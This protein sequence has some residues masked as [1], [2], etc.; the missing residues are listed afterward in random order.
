M[1]ASKSLASLRFRLSQAKQR[2]TTERRGW[3]ANPTWPAGFANDFDGNAGGAGD[4]L[5]SLGGVGE[6]KLDEWETAPR[7]LQQRHRPIAVLDRGRVNLQHQRPAVGI[8]QGVASRAGE[9]HPPG[10]GRRGRPGHRPGRA[11]SRPHRL[12]QC[13]A[14]GSGGL[15]GGSCV[16]ALVEDRR[17]FF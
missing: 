13:H 12:V 11:G 7:G 15:P 14:P 16:L 2:S 4:A 10:C 6:G 1:V 17:E 3:T 9:S 8:D 5:A